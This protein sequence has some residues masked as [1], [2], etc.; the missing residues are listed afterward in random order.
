MKRVLI[1]SSNRLGDT[2]LSSGLNNYYKDKYKD[3]QITF[4]CGEVPHDLF[5][6]CK[7]IDII[8]PLKKRK[9][10][11]HWLILFIKV[12]F[13]KWEEV[14]DLRGSLISFF[15]FTKKRNIFRK[16]TFRLIHKVEEITTNITGKLVEPKINILNTDF[17][18]KF[19]RKKVICICPTANW[20]PKIWPEENFLGL[21]KKISVNSKFNDYIFVLI[22]PKAEE[23]KIKGI[24]SAKDKRIFNMFGKFSLVEI[25]L[26][27]KECKLFIGNDSG[28]M[29]LAALARVR[30]VGLFG[31]SSTEKYRPW[32]GGTLHISGKKSPDDLMGH[33]NFDFRQ[34]ECLMKDLKVDYVLKKII[35]FYKK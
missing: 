4:V 32:G 10:S 25:F 29:H 31:P 35:K 15:L 30:T 13:K 9:Y 17:K 1:I 18:N 22:G 24:L 14:I 23:H 28:L 33:K 12:F 21:I 20:A 7:Y 5:R 3:S 2:I 27:L 6:Y 19:R 26:F 34:E 11:F 8:I 16:N